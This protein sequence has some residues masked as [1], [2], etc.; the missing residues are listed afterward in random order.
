MYPHIP[1]F[2][3]GQVDG[4]YEEIEHF[5]DGSIKPFFVLWF[6]DIKR[7]ARGRSFSDYKLDSHFATVDLVVVCRSGREARTLTNDINDQLIGFR[8]A[9]GGRLHKGTPL[10]SDS[11]QIMDSKNRLNRWARTVRFDFGIASR[12]VPTPAP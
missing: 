11:R 6:S 2:E 9:D 3:D 12:K 5:P 1:I 4:D 10:W 8:A 7:S